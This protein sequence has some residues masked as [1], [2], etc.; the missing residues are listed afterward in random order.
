[1]EDLDKVYAK[2]IAEE[3]S[4]KKERKAAQLKKLD[5]KAK[6][7][8]RIFAYTFGI[9]G[10]LVLGLGMS[11]FMTDF[12]SSGTLGVVLGIII[13]IVGFALC[14]INYPIYTKILNSR[15]QRYAYEIKELA[16]EIVKG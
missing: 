9:I 6:R 5:E 3:Y 16:K 13:G 7:P 8:A 2:C 4:S 1:M 12:G 14:G 11:F 15:K 10:A